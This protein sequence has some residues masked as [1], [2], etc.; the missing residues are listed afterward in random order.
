M[1][2]ICKFARMGKM[3]L[4]PRQELFCQE[5]MKHGDARKAM[6]AGYPKREGWTEGGQRTGAS[7]ILAGVKVQ[8]RL[9]EL[10]SQMAERGIIERDDIL[11]LCKRV[12]EGE[13]ITDGV[14]ETEVFDETGSRDESDGFGEERSGQP[15][16]VTRTR[17]R[18]TISRTWAAERAS[19]MCGYDAPAEVKVSRDSEMTRE[20]VLAE[21]ARL[22]KGRSVD[23][24]MGGSADH[25]KEGRSE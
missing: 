20:E 15:R 10:K 7:R 8:R 6:L 18:R 22:E 21:L 13:E 16:L 1:G 2:E 24:G 25:E 4:N 9:E 17:Q 14:T 19:R 23:S 3:S 11:R 12:L 5:Y